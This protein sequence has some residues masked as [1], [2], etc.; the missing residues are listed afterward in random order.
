MINHT[1]QGGA[2]MRAVRVKEPLRFD[3]APTELTEVWIVF[4]DD[5]VYVA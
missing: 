4:D 5:N 2:T 3:A 1:C